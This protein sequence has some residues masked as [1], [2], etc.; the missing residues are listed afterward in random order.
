[1][2]TGGFFSDLLQFLIMGIQRGSIYAMVAMGYNIIYNAT[3]V[4]NIAC[5]DQ[6]VH[7]VESLRIVVG[8]NGPGLSE[9]QK[10]KVF[11]P[12]FTTKAEGTGLGMAISKR[13]AEELGTELGGAVGWKVRFTDQVAGD[14]L[15]KLMT[16]GVLLAETGSDRF[17]D[18]YDVI[19]IDEA[20]EAPE[21][22]SQFF[23]ACA[24]VLIA[25]NSTPSRFSS[26]IRFTAFPPP[27]PPCWWKPRPRT[28]QPSPPMPKPSPM[29]WKIA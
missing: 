5:E 28:G 27:P 25:T 21:V 24:S 1:M 13:I 20:H 16:D 17:L 19:I 7:G 26:I 8:D 9:E 15:V 14:T 11:E 2:N 6:K 3:G 10:S 29:R 18:Q 23:S 22:A 4:I 12:F